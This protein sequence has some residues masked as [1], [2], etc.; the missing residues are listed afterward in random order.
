M[1]VDT[2]KMLELSATQVIIAKP[3]KFE[4]QLFRIFANSKKW[5]QWIQRK[6]PFYKLF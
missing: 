5:T 1:I 3:R 4:L 6:G 2:V